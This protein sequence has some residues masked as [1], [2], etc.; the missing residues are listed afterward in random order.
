MCQ[1]AMFY[2]W[3]T[4]LIL[5]DYDILQY[6]KL[7]E[8]GL[9]SPFD[10]A[11][12][13]PASYDLRLSA[14]TRWFVKDQQLDT[15]NLVGHT[16][17]YEGEQFLLEPGEFILGA[18]EETVRLPLELAARVE[19]KSSLGRLGLM[20]HVTAGYIDPEF[21]GQIT[22]E[23]KN[24]NNVPIVLHA[25]MRIAQIAFE[26]MSSVPMKG[27]SQTGHYQGQEGPTESR[28]RYD[29]PGG[30]DSRR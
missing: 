14:V 13:N 24:I 4:A 17:P 5:S 7:Y 1:L 10:K 26:R 9:I 3:R 25:G 29:G 11:Q 27:Y 22:L 30:Q 15:R 8:G 16:V 28:Y 18:T 19:G 21:S 23:I 2:M 20:V 12:V 6:Q